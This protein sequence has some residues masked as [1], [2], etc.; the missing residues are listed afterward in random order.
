MALQGKKILLGVTGS[1]AAYKAAML[2]RLLVKEG[3]EVQVVM[4]EGAHDFITPLTLSVLSKN[5]VQTKYF[6]GET[7][8]WNNHVSLGIWAD[9][10]LIAPA[11][12]NTI[13]AMANGSCNNLLQAV[14]L[15]ARCPV[16][17]ALAM[18]L[19]M[20]KHPAVQ[21]NINT[22]ASFGHD[23]FDAEEGEL[24]SGLEGK[25]RMMEPDNILKKLIV[26]LP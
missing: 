26:I 19:D 10:F 14:Y 21:H 1:I 3:A 15:S 8:V 23:I 22:L 16:G 20:Y 4:T 12:A 24:A 11:T 9:Y 7:G 13:A 25:G 6:D 17:I 18:D 5:P 2:V